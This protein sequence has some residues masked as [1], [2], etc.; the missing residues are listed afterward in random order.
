MHRLNRRAFL[1]RSRKTGLSWAA[2]ATILAN[3]QRIAG[4][5]GLRRAVA[6]GVVDAMVRDRRY[7]RIRIIRRPIAN[8]A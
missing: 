8:S 3:A 2:G 7:V 1:E 4:G 6:V 5:V